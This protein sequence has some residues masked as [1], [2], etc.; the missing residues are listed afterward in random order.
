MH[1]CTLAYLHRIC[2][3]KWHCWISNK[4]QTLK[5]IFFSCRNLYPTQYFSHNSLQPLLQEALLLF[6]FKLAIEVKMESSSG[7]SEESW[8][9]K[10][11]K[12]PW[13]PSFLSLNFFVHT[14]INSDKLKGCFE[15]KGETSHW[16]PWD[17]DS[18]QWQHFVFFFWAKLTHQV[19]GRQGWPFK[20]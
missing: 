12:T 7:K 15:A 8:E 20:Q 18:L 17:S 2:S 13:F 16:N 4:L 3:P 19:P 14:L 10:A 6:F 5:K 9:D 1:L 11:R